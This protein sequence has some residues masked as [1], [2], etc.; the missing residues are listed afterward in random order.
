MVSRDV[1]PPHLGP[2]VPVPA[3]KASV[4]FYFSARTTPTPIFSWLIAQW[5]SDI[6]AEKKPSVDKMSRT[7]LK[8]SLTRAEQSWRRTHF[9]AFA[10]P[11]YLRPF[12]R[13]T[14]NAATPDLFQFLQQNLVRSVILLFFLVGGHLSA[15]L[16]ETHLSAK[17]LF[18][19]SP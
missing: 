3:G 4:L 19:F 15:G 2:A 16:S 18:F 7:S 6:W 13:A 14:V 11:I 10:D 12:A 5:F 8:N 1:L 9:S 17:V